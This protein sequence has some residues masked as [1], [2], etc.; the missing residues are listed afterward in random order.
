[1]SYERFLRPALFRLDPEA[2]HNLAL[3]AISHGLIRGR[4]LDDPR[5]R[6]SA[7]GLDFP[8]PLGLAAG[9][10][11]NGSAVNRW[12]GLGFG[13]AEIGTVTARPQPGNVRPRLFRLPEQR[14]VINRMGFNNH[15]ARDLAMAM[16][17]RRTSIPVGVNLGKSK[18]T[19][20]SEAPDDYLFSYRHVARF[21]DYV[22][23]N[24]SSPN[25]PG[26]RDLQGVSA[27][28][29]IVMPLLA[30]P[31]S[32]PLFVKIAP[33]LHL[34]DITQIAMMSKEV[35]LAGIVATNTTLDHSSISAKQDQQG[36]L[37]GAPLFE[38][39]TAI[40][41]HIKSVAPELV[42][43]GVG[44]VFSGADLKAKLDAGATWV[45]VYT[46]WVYGGPLMPYR[47]LS[48]YLDLLD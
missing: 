45:Q 14:A 8:N 25:T 32:R 28:R 1:M 37:S 12:A 36:G 38:K 23:V 6:F 44:G 31:L 16:S 33:D 2:A 48:E 19:P 39:S 35:G 22:V 26:L 29:D 4:V 24:V 40:I 42:V 11:K 17:K 21:A 9:V 5:L 46:G 30:E 41:R 15:G 18:V 13:S 43:V 34:D 20:L 7:C 27:L 10:D 3:W 47:V